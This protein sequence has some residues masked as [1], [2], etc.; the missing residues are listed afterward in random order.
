M[1]INEIY[2]AINSN[3]Q[4]RQLM[5]TAPLNIVE[6][7]QVLHYD[8][9]EFFLHQDERYQD[10]YLLVKGRVKVFLISPNGKQVVLDVYDSG[11]FL[12]EQEAIIKRPYSASVINIS[13]VTV[14]KMHNQDFTEWTH[15]DHHFADC[16][17]HNL[18]EQ[19]YHLT[20]RME[21]YSLHSALQQVCLFLLECYD[22]K[23]PITREQ[24]TYAVD[25]S[26]RNI[27]RVLKRLV[28]LSI[29]KVE[30]STINIIN[31]PLLKELVETED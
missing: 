22:N 27:N 30:H 4:V 20:K 6:H 23:M 1:N 25:T 18:S 10:T 2:E 26:Y 14:L 19:I 11:M 5:Q 31:Y 29:I 12:G 16:L 8:T 15:Q 17:V 24:I 7:L 13:P 9:K 21:R 28:D 3:N